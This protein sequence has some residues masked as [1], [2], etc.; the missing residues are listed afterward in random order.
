MSI[1][2]GNE[3]TGKWLR[4][5]DGNAGLFPK[6]IADKMKNKAFNNFDE[7]REQFWKEVANDPAL[8]NQFSPSNLTRMRDGLSPFVRESQQLGGQMTYVLHHKTP[9]NQGGAVY[10][11]DNLLIVTPRYHKEILLPEFHYGYGY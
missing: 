7:F 2:N 4:G 10:D 8:A 9:I 6:S 1:G 5:S 3:I 11:I